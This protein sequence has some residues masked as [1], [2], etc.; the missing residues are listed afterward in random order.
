MNKVLVVEDTE[1]WQ[2]EIRLALEKAGYKV[3]SANSQFDVIAAFIRSGIPSLV[4]MDMSL[5][6]GD[7]DDRQG[8]E[9]LRKVDG[10]PVLSISGYLSADEVENLR[11]QNLA[12]AFLDK[13][14]FD[15]NKL[16]EAVKESIS[17]R[18]VKKQLK[19]S[20]IL[21]ICNLLRQIVLASVVCAFILAVASCVLMILAYRNVQFYTFG[22][23]FFTGLS[24]FCG[25][26][27]IE[28]LLGIGLLVR[29]YKLR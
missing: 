14:D 8:L 25:G 15:K 22:K 12:D 16:L 27:S 11:T 4:I 10:I 1:N 19:R 20:K 29:S 18:D 17:S 13:N 21:R 5:S 3:T 23:G 6:P 7:A 24:V 26:L 28:F 9:L 2:R